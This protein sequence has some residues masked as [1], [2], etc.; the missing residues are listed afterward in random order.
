MVLIELSKLDDKSRN[1]LLY[2]NNNSKLSSSIFAEAF[3]QHYKSDLN[4]AI[5]TLSLLESKSLVKAKPQNDEIII[6]IQV[7]HSGR[8]YEQDLFGDIEDF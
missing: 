7:T 5:E 2:L 8:T 1:M 3:N 6:M 4:E